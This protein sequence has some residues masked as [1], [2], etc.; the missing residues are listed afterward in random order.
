MRMMIVSGK[1]VNVNDFCLVVS[2]KKMKGSG[3]KQGDVVMVGG[4]KPVPISAKDP[5]LQRIC[6]V[7]F[8]VDGELQVPREDNEYKAYLVDPRNLEILP[9]EEQ[10]QLLEMLKKQY[11]QEDTAII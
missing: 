7:V 2:A 1:L 8:K 9:D 6:V 4:H 11:G 5:Y 3:L 10:A